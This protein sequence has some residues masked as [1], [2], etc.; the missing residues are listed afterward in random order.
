MIRDFRVSY[1]KN[2]IGLD[3]TPVFSWKLVSEKKECGAK[4]IPV[5]GNLSRQNDMG[6]GTG[7]V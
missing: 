6:Y 3:E 1:R 4:S 7:G 2:P 5:A